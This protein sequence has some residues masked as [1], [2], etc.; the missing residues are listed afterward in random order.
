MA[1]PKFTLG[2]NELQFS[3]GLVY[4]V[5]K[6]H[7]KGQ[8]IDRTAAGTPQVEDLGIN[9]HRRYLTFKNLP[10]ADYDA[11]RTWYDSICNGAYNSF[12]YT[13]ENG[14]AMTVRMVTNP[15]EFQEDYYQR[16][17]GELILEVVS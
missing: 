15:L 10:Q 17:S 1:K 3:R 14:N 5:R 6:P 12:I 2:A 8:V 4:P 7:E 11:L 16:F 13:D 9:I